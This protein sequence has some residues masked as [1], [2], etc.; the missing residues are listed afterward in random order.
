MHENCTCWQCVLQHVCFCMFP[1]GGPPEKGVLSGEKN[2]PKNKNKLFGVLACR[3][4]A[5]N[6]LGVVSFHRCVHVQIKKQRCAVRCCSRNPP[7]VLQKKLVLGEIKSKKLEVSPNNTDVL[8]RITLNLHGGTSST[9]PCRQVASASNPCHLP[10][11]SRW[12]WKGGRRQQ[13]VEGG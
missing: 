10:T 12:W 5:N 8:L 4:K 9:S 11:R 13:V 6:T 2:V 7:A 1:T 3:A